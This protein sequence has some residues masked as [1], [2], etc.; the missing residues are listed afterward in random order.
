MSKKQLLELIVSFVITLLLAWGVL[1]LNGCTPVKSYR[2]KCTKEQSELVAYHV[3]VCKT[4][5]SSCYHYAVE[6]LC[7]KVEDK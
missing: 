6:N 1:H 4:A 2:Y 7:D 5:T 3:N